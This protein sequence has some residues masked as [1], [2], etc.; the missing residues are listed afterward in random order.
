MGQT[1]PAAGLKSLNRAADT[2]STLLAQEVK[3]LNER[4]KAARRENTPDP[5]MMKG[6]KEATAVL[7]DLAGVVK[8]LNDQG[9]ELE[10]TE[11]G[12]VLLPP[13]EQE[14]KARAGLSVQSSCGSRSPGSWNLCA[15][16]NRKRCT[17]ARRAAARA[18]HC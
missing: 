9:T 10:G 13:V 4:Q 1:K 15:D 5:G 6:L 14:E 17:A 18:M 16:R 2:L 7:K 11:C 8:T 3:E 12:V